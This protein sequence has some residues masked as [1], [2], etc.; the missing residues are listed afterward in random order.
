MNTEK[1]NLNTTIIIGVII[2]GISLLIFQSMKQNFV[3]KQQQEKIEQEQKEKTDKEDKLFY[4]K[5]DANREYWDY[6]KDNGTQNKETFY[7][8]APRYVWDE[9]EK[10][11][12]ADLDNCYKDLKI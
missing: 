2:L 3:I 6:V 4:C 9:A 8:T 11:K 10:N 1:L 7:I 12:Q 5:A